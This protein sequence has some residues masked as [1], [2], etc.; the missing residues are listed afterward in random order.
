MREQGYQDVVDAW[1]YYLKKYNKGRGVVLIGHSQGTCV[2]R[3]LITQKVDPKRSVRKRLISALLMGGNVLV[4]TGSDRGGD[5]QNIP[6]CRSSRQFG[7]VVA[8]STFD[9]PGAGRLALRTDG[10]GRPRGP[11]HQPHRPRRQ[12]GRA[13]SIMPTEPFAQGTVIGNL[14]TQ[15]GFV[16]P[17]SVTTPWIE[18][19]QGLQGALLLG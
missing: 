16:V 6:A 12:A 3:R 7:C 13:T 1:R 14:T 19:P 8:F 18:V 15:I 5:F 11:V 17:E 10:A 9:G 2:L 4:K